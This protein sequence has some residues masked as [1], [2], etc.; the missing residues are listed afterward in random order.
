ML[1]DH[2]PSSTPD[3]SSVVKG[4]ENTAW[5]EDF[6]VKPADTHNLQRPET[7]ESLFYMWRITG[8][9]M[10]RRWGWEIFEAFVKHTAVEGDG[11]FS[12]IQNVNSEGLVGTRDNM[13]SFWPVRSPNPFFPFRFSL[14]SNTQAETLKYLYLLFGPDDILP[15]DKVVFNTEAHPFPRFELGKNFFTGWKRKPRDSE[16]RLLEEV[17]A[18]EANQKIIPPAGGG[19]DASVGS[20]GKG[21]GNVGGG[22][23]R[24][25]V[26]DRSGS[27]GRLGGVRRVEEVK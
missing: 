4:L 8:D 14:T 22:N 17:A 16:G 7:V 26:V 10:Y 25:E 1:P 13:E 2:Q 20:M 24:D 18:V 9:E 12:S 5:T 15:L 3:F 23:N 11:G 27:Q 19:G 6:V 21:A